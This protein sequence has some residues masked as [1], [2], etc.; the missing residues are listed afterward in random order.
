MHAR[1]CCRCATV[2]P[3]CI[4][5]ILCRWSPLEVKVRT[6]VRELRCVRRGH[7]A[8]AHV[9]ARRLN[10]KPT[11]K[12]PAVAISSANDS[13]C[14][15][16]RGETMSTCRRCC[17]TVPRPSRAARTVVRTPVQPDPRCSRSFVGTFNARSVYD[18]IVADRLHLCAVVE[19]WHDAVDSPQLIACTPP[20]YSYLEKARPRSASAALTT[21]TN[22]GQL[23][24][25]YASFIPAKYHCQSTTPAPKFLQFIFAAP[26]VMCWLLSYIDPR[27][28][29]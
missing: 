25:F 17:Q 20:G 26:D 14:C 7:R 29:P 10:S 22:H 8:G 19:T 21:R 5:K 11:W 6:L 18:R 24:L 2:G 12:T 13:D 16:A 23:C 3:E 27:T 1:H 9:Q 28:P 15:N 4:E